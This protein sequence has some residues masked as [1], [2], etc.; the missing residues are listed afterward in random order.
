MSTSK[1]KCLVKKNIIPKLFNSY[2][3][4]LCIFLNSKIKTLLQV[5]QFFFSCTFILINDSIKKYLKKNKKTIMY[6]FCY[7]KIEQLNLPFYLH[8]IQ[9]TPIISK[10]RGK[11]IIYT[12][13]HSF[14]VFHFPLT[15]MDE[16]K[17]SEAR[18][19][20]QKKSNEK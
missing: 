4:V 14:F 19:K 8:T 15:L 5:L 12:F 11:S 3:C 13:H 16:S 2:K 7:T 18:N 10:M 20:K 9:N 1:F 17:Y 6:L